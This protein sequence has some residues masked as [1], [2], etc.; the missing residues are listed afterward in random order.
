MSSATRANDTRLP[1]RQSGNEITL[2][3]MEEADDSSDE[4]DA[5]SAGAKAVPKPNEGPLK[6]T[7]GAAVEAAEVEVVIASCVLPLRIKLIALRQAAR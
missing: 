2:V 6:P 1:V 4:E 3:D 5:T 7:G